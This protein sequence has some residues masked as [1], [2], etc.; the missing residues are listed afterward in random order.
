MY[1]LNSKNIK[2]FEIPIISYICYKTLLLSSIFNK[3][4]S[5]D[6]KTFREEESIEILSYWLNL[7]Q[8]ITLKMSQNI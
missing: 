3:S 2:E 1:C 7:K 8:V 5:E 6:G 4:G